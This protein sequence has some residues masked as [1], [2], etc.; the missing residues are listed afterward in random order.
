MFPDCGVN[1]RS[2][3]SSRPTTTAPP[4]G[5]KAKARQA[6]GAVATWMTCW[7]S[8]AARFHRRR[9]SSPHDPKI[10]SR[11]LLHKGDR[12]ERNPIET[13]IASYFQ[14]YLGNAISEMLLVWQVERSAMS[15]VSVSI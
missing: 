14:T 6:A 2:E 12:M 9:P 5:A 8:E 1:A 13:H 3:P 7:W 11:D 4:S 15:K 10:P